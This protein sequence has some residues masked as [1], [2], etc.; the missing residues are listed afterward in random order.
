MKHKLLL[1]AIPL[2]FFSLTGCAGGYKDIDT[3]RTVQEGT[4]VETDHKIRVGI[5]QP[6]EHIALGLARQGFVDGLKEAGYVDGKNITIDYRN[7]GG[8]DAA[9]ST[10]AKTLI[11]KNEINLGIGTGASLSL[12][13]AS[14]NA[15][16]TNPLLFTAVTDPVDAKLVNNAKAPEGY[17]TGTSDMNPVEAQVQLIKECLPNATKI[18]ILYTKTETNSVVQADMAKAEAEKQGF[19]VEIETVDNSSQITAKATKL[20]ESCQAIY[21]PTDNNIAANMN[22]VKVPA[23]N[24]HCLIVAG[25]EGMLEGGAHIT[26]SIDYYELGKTTGK[27]AVS[28]INGSKTVSQLPV[29]YMSSEECEYVLNSANLTSAGITLPEAVVAKCRDTS[30]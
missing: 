11:T 7:A 15:G 10:Q 17:V 6:V 21:L 30:K 24:A 26:L 28:L 9:Q 27:M 18:G 29:K 2:L 5:L 1:T 20:A 16:K 4:L 22:A 23:D 13:S 14:D 12:K 3:G 8:K 25:E 19:E